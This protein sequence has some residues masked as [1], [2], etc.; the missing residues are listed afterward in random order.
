M[1]PI[2]DNTKRSKD[3]LIA[4]A[5]LAGIDIIS[6][7]LGLY[8]NKALAKYDIGEYS[9]ENFNILDS[10]VSILGVV[11]FVCIIIVIV[12]FIKW[13]R[14]AYGNLIRLN[15]IME[16]S[17]NQ[18]VWGYF[19]PFINWVRPAKTAKEIYIKTQ[20][21]IKTYQESLIV[22]KDTN[23]ITLWW[24]IYLINGVISRVASK[25]IQRAETIDAYIEANTI[26]IFS[27]V[28]DIL[29]IGLA[30]LVVQKISKLELIL[31]NTDT[32][33]SLIDQIGTTEL[34]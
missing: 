17:E 5:I 22:D 26:Y 7:L 12:L 21:I 11:Q 34:D 29:S 1:N 14:R 19:I 20:K 31:K 6:I 4:F 30:I 2:K 8:Q 28:W 25:N 33:T 23:L 15:V 13:F 27:D 24:I 16:Y 18:V 9:E 32:S 10:V 3:V